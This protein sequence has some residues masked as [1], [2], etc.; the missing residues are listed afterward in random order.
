MV[1]LIIVFGISHLV[2]MIPF[3]PTSDNLDGQ[4]NSGG[5]DAYI[6]KFNKDGSKEWTRL[7]GTSENDSGKFITTGSD[8]AIYILGYTSDYDGGINRGTTISKFNPDGTKVWTNHR[9]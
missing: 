8:G 1:L 2:M 9:L 6:A 5:G 4:V 3:I 7:F